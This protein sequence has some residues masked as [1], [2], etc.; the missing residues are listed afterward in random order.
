MDDVGMQYGAVFI[1]RDTAVHGARKTDAR[2]AF[3]IDLQKQ[4][5]DSVEYSAYDF[6]GILFR[7]VRLREI[8]GIIA[9]DCGKR[10]A[11]RVENG[12]FAAGSAGIQS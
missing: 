9:A 6:I 7:P 10:F 8:G 12:T 1:Y 2:D 5:A 4:F 11:L 3:G